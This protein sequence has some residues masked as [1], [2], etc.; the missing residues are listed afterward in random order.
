MKYYS[1]T[2]SGLATVL[3]FQSATLSYLARAEVG[4]DDK[5]KGIEEG[6]KKGGAVGRINPG[7]KIPQEGA[8]KIAPSVGGNMKVK[9]NLAKSARFDLLGLKK[10]KANGLGGA[11]LIGYY[12]LERMFLGTRHESSPQY[13]DHVVFHSFSG[14]VIRRLAFNS[15]EQEKDII[16]RLSLKGRLPVSIFVRALSTRV[17]HDGVNMSQRL[18]Y[19]VIYHREHEAAL[20]SSGARAAGESG[21]NILRFQAALKADAQ[22]G[23]VSYTLGQVYVSSKPSPSGSVLWFNG[24]RIYNSSDKPV[25]VALVSA[26]ITQA[27]VTSECV[28]NPRWNPI[29]QWEVAAK[30]WSDGYYE[31]GQMPRNKWAFD[32]T[33]TI[34][35]NMKAVVSVVLKVNGGKEITLRRAVDP[36]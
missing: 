30:H 29:D 34:N 4:I 14:E 9:P 6:F 28:L 17:G 18:S 1:H 13:S 3:F 11:N 25:S 33:A 22:E 12:D 20:I 2:L 26:S 23:D 27:G 5:A 16:K 35:A 21:N 31:T 19:K 15:P 7:F 24:I 36:S 10:L 8:H 32:S